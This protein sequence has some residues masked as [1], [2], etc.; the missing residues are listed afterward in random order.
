MTERRPRA[1]INSAFGAYL[2]K[3]ELQN[4]ID[5][6]PLLHHAHQDEMWI[7][8]ISDTGDGFAPTYSMAW[9]AAQDT[10]EVAGVE[11]PRADVVVLGGDEVYP[12]ASVEEY[13]S[14][15]IGPYEASLPWL[16]DDNPEMYFVAR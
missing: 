4:V 14:R 9:L 11:L 1:A 7:D 12:V 2:D 15:F 5:A 16:A 10:V 13:A 8:Y 6:A 3:R